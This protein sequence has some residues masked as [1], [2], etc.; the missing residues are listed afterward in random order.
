AA[1]PP[2]ADEAAIVSATLAGLDARAAGTP[3]LPG[4]DLEVTITVRGRGDEQPHVG[5][6]IEQ[7]RGVGITSMVTHEE[8]AAPRRLADGT[9]RS[10]LTLP[11][12]PLHSGEYV[13][14]VYLF[15]HS[16]LVVYDQWHQFLS[17]RFVAP[18][19]TPGLVRLPHRWS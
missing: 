8:G 12:L 3:L 19:R 13:V 1:P 7:T 10:V 15:D 6:M 9:W 5:F 4:P 16:G 18:V 2:A 14:S 17:F 11:D